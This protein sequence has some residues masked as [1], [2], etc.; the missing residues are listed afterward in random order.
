MTPRAKAL[1]AECAAL[2]CEPVVWGQSDCSTWPARWVADITER[3]VTYP[4]YA[5]REQADEAIAAAGGLDALWRM[6]AAEVGLA[7]IALPA[8]EPELGDI[9]LV[10]TRAFGVVGGVFGRGVFFWRADPGVRA[11][12]IRPSTLVAAWRVP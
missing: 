5:S 6:V 3:D 11:L 10:R 8:E 12:T 7:A 2:E 1:A 9:G 4:A